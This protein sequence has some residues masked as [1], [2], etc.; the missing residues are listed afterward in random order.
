MKTLRKIRLE[1][2]HKIFVNR[3]YL[4]NFAAI[5]FRTLENLL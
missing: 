5:Q 1:K 3:I 2:K 4:T